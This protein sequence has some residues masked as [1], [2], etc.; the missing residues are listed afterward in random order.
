ML[1]GIYHRSKDGIVTLCESSGESYYE[2]AFYSLE[3]AQGYAAQS[4]QQ[5]KSQSYF[6][7]PLDAGIVALWIADQPCNFSSRPSRRKS[8]R[9]HCY[10]SLTNPSNKESTL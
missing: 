9:Y 6:A 2:A 1:Y 4:N 8:G 10:D 5:F 7:A 3:S